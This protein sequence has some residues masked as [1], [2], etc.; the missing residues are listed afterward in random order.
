MKLSCSYNDSE[1]NDTVTYVGSQFNGLRVIK[2][3]GNWD[4]L[5]YDVWSFPHRKQFSLKLLTCIFIITFTTHI[6]QNQF[7]IVEV[8]QV[9]PLNIYFVQLFLL[10]SNDISYLLVA[11][12]D[13]GHSD[14]VVPLPI[15][16]RTAYDIQRQGQRYIQQA[17]W[18]RLFPFECHL[19]NVK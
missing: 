17:P 4:F 5:I 7:Q 15:T 1:W 16:E 18:W 9:V 6:F 14:R 2:R 19:D 10:S 11:V 13:L 8:L 12:F 3:K